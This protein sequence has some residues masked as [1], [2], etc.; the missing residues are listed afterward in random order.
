MFDY[1]KAWDKFA[2]KAVTDAEK[3][4]GSDDEA[5]DFI[6]A[7]NPK[8]V[9]EKAPQSQA[10]MMKRTSGARPNTKLVIKGGTVKKSS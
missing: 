4:N 9:E 6:P 2:D 8:A 1:Y 10:E 5:Q 7:T 3:E